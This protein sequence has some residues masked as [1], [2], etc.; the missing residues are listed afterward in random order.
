ML[1]PKNPEHNYRCS[2]VRAT[3]NVSFFTNGLR[4]FG[5][6]W[7]GKFLEG[8]DIC[9]LMVRFDKASDFGH[10]PPGKRSH[11]L[12]WE[13]EIHLQVPWQGIWYFPGGYHFCLKKLLV[14]RFA[15]QESTEIQR[16]KN[17]KNTTFLD[18]LL[19]QE[20]PKNIN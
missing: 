13:K 16:T 9:D 12:P 7:R 19:C 10:Y 20:H 17:E 15:F 4:A 6:V 14:R 5:T 1:I 2:T 3:P 11:I 8:L 18:Q